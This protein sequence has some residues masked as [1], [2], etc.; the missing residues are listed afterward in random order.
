MSF[1]RNLTLQPSDLNTMRNPKAR[2]NSLFHYESVANQE[3]NS[4]ISLDPE[5][6]KKLFLNYQITPGH[7]FN[8][9]HKTNFL[10]ENKSLRASERANLQ[11]EINSH[12]K[13]QKY[14]VLL[15]KDSHINNLCHKKNKEIKD[16]F[17]AR[18]L[19]LK[20]NLTQ[21]IKE[22]LIFAKNNSPIGAMLQPEVAEFLDKKKIE[23]DNSLISYSFESTKDN[24]QKRPKTDRSK[25]V[26]KIQKKKKNEFLRLIGVDVE[27]LSLNN[28]NLDIDKAWNY[29]LRWGKG[30]DVEE[31]LRLKVVNAIMALTEQ[32]AAG[33]VRHINDKYKIYKQHKERQ[34]QEMLKKKKEEEEKRL[35][36]L[37]KMDPRELIRG[38]MKESLGHKGNFKKFS[39]SLGVLRKRQK[40]QEE[41]KRIELNSYKD[42]DKILAIIDNS[43]KDSKSRLFEQHFRN[44]RTRKSIDLGKEKAMEKNKLFDVNN[45]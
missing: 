7:V 36:E 31:I 25:T 18:K 17:D 22:S 32:N 5:G 35:E 9:F 19:R 3:Y 11:T 24:T 40:K 38:K 8:V 6:E 23:L 28:I 15:E 13:K 21:L 39:H 20:N 16:E 43:S 34:R 12:I 2:S 33:K 29:I 30:R 45:K 10:E 14:Q 42:V 1:K 27:N 4:R 26:K 37:R 44:I 41:K